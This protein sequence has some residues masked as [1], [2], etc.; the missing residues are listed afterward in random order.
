MRRQEIDYI[1]A[2]MLGSHKDVSDLNITVGK[3]FQVES[4]GVLRRVDLKP[5]FNEL[6]P[7]QTGA[8]NPHLKGPGSARGLLENSA[9]KK[10]TCLGDRGHRIW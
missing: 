8:Q 5:P 1:L 3:P 6:T 7:F 10:R 4:D 2:R 9:G